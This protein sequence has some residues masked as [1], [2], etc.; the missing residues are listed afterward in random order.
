VARRA[1][2]FFLHETD[3]HIGLTKDRARLNGGDTYTVASIAATGYALTALPIGVENG[4]ISREGAKQRALVTLRFLH[5]RMPNVHGWF[6]HFVDMRTGER[7]W[8]CELSSIDTTLLMA[9]VVAVGQYWPGTEVSRL[10]DALQTRVDWTWMRTDGGAK[11]QELTV[12]MGW[13]PEDGFL[14]SRWSHYCEHILLYVLGIGAPRNPLPVESWSAWSRRIETNEGY[15]VIFPQ[16][17]F[18]HQMSH[19]YLDMRG[20]RDRLG[21]DYWQNSVNAHLAQAAFCA[22]HADRFAGYRGG[23][24]GLNASDTPDGYG[25]REPKDDRHDGTLCPTGAVAGLPIVPELAA[26]SVQEMHRRYG[27]HIWG[28]YGFANAFNADRN[29]WGPDVIGI[30]LGMALV[31]Y[32]DAR[33][34]FV[35]RL[36]A[37]SPIIRRGMRRAGFHRT[38]EPLPRPVLLR[39]RPDARRGPGANYLPGPHCAATATTII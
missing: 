24:W 11:P 32:E 36:M 23:I 14:N 34:G 10:A 16:G 38:T 17:I 39:P 33:T 35:W 22:R 15:D 9:G 4:W 21:F 37:R 7:V 8:N 6:Y 18:I 27:D 13:K 28:R 31:A 2:D 26:H 30:D 3:P 12:C 5:G 29:W 25:V 1:F 19:G 20:R